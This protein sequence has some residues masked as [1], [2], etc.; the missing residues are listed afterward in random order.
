MTI[1]TAILV[2]KLREF[3][4][5]GVMEC[6]KALETTNG[7]FETA[8]D[9]I[10]KIGKIKVSK[11][12]NRSILEGAIA[13]KVSN[14]C[15]SAFMVEVNCE[16]DFVSRGE[17]FVNFVKSVID[18][19]LQYNIDDLNELYKLKNNAG[20]TVIE[21]KNN[22]SELVGEN[23]N[24]RR[25]QCMN[26]ING[27]IGH[28]VHTNN[29]IG[30]LVNV[31]GENNKLGKDLAMHIVATKPHVINIHDLSAN[32]VQ[33]E[34]E[35]FVQQ[36]SNLN[37]PSHILE[38]MIDGRMKQYFGEIVLLKQPFIKENNITIEELLH[39]FDA[40]IFNFSY[41]ELGDGMEKIKM[42]FLQDVKNQINE[43]SS[44]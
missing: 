38:K 17:L 23:I 39:Q 24:I 40:E 18:L 30:A 10:R 19:G 13:I 7:D 33:K 34:K 27:I 22:L 9:L 29:K 5:A 42:D 15:K 12:I 44:F 21:L 32:V 43:K 1:I 31:S 14:S 41:F 2:K 6:K 26:V 25:I 8:V 4:G 37:K 35:I 3:T 28:Y 16:T 11:K 20:K 36:F